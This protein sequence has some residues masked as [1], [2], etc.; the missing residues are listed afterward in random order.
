MDFK[1]KLGFL[2][3]P[4]APPAP[5]PPSDGAGLIEQL[6]L[7][8]AEILERP[9]FK[10]PPRPP[11]DPSE[12]ALPFVRQD[13][14]AGPLYRRH[15]VLPRSH[16]VGRIPVDSAY[17]SRAELLAL[18]ALDPELAGPVEG[19]RRPSRGGMV[20]RGRGGASG[21]TPPTSSRG[22]GGRWWGVFCY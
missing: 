7:K 1:S 11:A 16:H 4:P 22:Q 12:T 17:A 14:E 8:M 13:T 3:P 9:R 15:V 2:P 18:L 6:R 10:V 21:S 19:E 20:R 5:E